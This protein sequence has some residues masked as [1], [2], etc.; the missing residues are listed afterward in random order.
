MAGK[1]KAVKA[2]KPGTGVTL[3]KEQMKEAAKKQ[4][5]SEKVV[6]GFPSIS[7]RG[8]VLSID[9]TPVKDN[10]M[11]MVIL[12]AVHENAYY[13]DAY[14]PANAQ[15]PV[16]YA[17]AGEG[18]DPDA[19]KPHP[20]SAEPQCATCADCELNQM[21][22][23]ETGRGK[24]CKNIRRLAL[25]TEDA[26]ADAE[27]FDEAEIRGLKVPVTST[28]N[29]AKYVKRL[30]EEQELPTFGVVTEIE[31]LRDPKTQFKLQFSFVS[32][33]AFSQPLFDAV[34]KK[35]AELAKDMVL[36]Y[37]QPSEDEPAPRRGKVNK[38]IAGKLSTNARTPK[39]KT[40][41]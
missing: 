36:P 4:A 8:G 27:A 7:T 37:Q 16:C 11:D 32:E 41:R 15:I 12:M 20:D 30:D 19:M 21:G 5:A 17:F 13:P 25:T 29:F 14:D 9:D 6:G 31:A 24:A 26:F 18:D 10:K 2:K 34:T 40:H 38:K 35:R 22:S 28:R 33:L 39:N 23:A 1:A 3:W